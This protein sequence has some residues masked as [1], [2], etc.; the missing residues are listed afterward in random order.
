MNRSS[1]RER[2][3]YFPGVLHEGVLA[4]NPT[5]SNG[6]AVSP[7][8][9]GFQVWETGGGFTAWGLHL[10]DGR[11]ILVTDIAGESHDLPEVGEPFLVGLHSAD[12]EQLGVWTM[13]VGCAYGA[14]DRPENEQGT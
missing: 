6:G 13:V 8:H 12:Y 10:P 9:F 5:A 14:D 1:A 2:Y 11:E 7:A 4:A 3:R